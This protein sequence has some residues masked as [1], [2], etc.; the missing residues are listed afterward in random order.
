MYRTLAAGLFAAGLSLP[1]HATNWLQLQG[2]EAPNAPKLK[3]FGFVQPTYTYIDADPIAGLAGSA[4]AFNGQ[5]SVPNLVGPDLEAKHD[6]EFMRARFGLRGRLSDAINYFVLTE[7]GR[8]AVTSQHEF[9]FTD[10]SLTFNYIP[11]ARIRAGLFKVPAGEEALVAVHTSYPYVYFTNATQ[12]LLVENQVRFDGGTFSATGASTAT[13]VSGG[14]GFR[15][16]G[17][18]VYDWFGKGPWEYS[19]AA[20]L[21]NGNEVEDLGDNDGAKD[22]TLRL[23][24]SYVFGNS[25]GP[26]REDLSIYLWRQD[27][28]RRFNGQ[29][30]DRLRQGLGIKYLKGPWRVS[31]EYLQGDGMI[32]AG[33]N[34]P[35]VGQPIQV[36]VNEK[37]TGWYLE[38]GWRFLPKWE[39]DFRHDLYDRMTE[40]AAL[41][42]AFTTD[43]LGLQYFI[44]GD[45]RLTLN[46]EWRDLEVSHPEAIAAGAQRNNALAIANNLGDRIS[47]QLTW[48]F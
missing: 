46:Y 18:Q 3:P 5:Y 25:K 32:V 10:A 45:T 40:N 31:G 15:D 7:A 21:S 48:S 23:Q 1:A 11:G 41:E 38:G 16:W 8:N 42:R 27:G 17:V 24:A 34:P 43:T 2:N 6:L 44:N 19:Y 4:A 9:M 36:G 30:F 28:E 26:N 22:L 14:S 20:M 47:L 33:P 35:F 12:N 39:V 13:T 29:A 37:S